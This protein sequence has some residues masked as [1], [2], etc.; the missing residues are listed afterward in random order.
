MSSCP[1][2][3]RSLRICHF[4][5]R[6]HL[7]Q[8]ARDGILSRQSASQRQ[9]D[10]PAVT[11]PLLSSRIVSLSPDLTICICTRNR[12]EA[13]A[14]ALSSIKDSAAPVARVV[15]SDDGPDE[16]T[17]ALVV[18]S[19]LPAT[20]TVGPGRGLAANRNHALRHVQSRYVLFLD[21][22]CRLAPNF[23]DL[24]SAAMQEHESR[25]GHGSV[26]VTGAEC[27]NGTIVTPSDQ[28]FL[29][30]QARPYRECVGLKTVV[31]NS[32]VFPTDR[33]QRALFDSRL[34]YGCEEVDLTTRLVADGATIVYCGDAVNDHLQSLDG[35]TGYAVE[36][37]AS[38]LYV[39]F[40]RYAFT[41]RRRGAACAFAVLAPL[42]MLV[43]AATRR[44]GKLTVTDALVAILRASAHALS[45]AFEH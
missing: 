21:D 4:L 6:H 41:D 17:R 30:F 39:T 20:Y 33:V 10:L 26:I 5:R 37:A 28:T 22:D 45:F 11:P 16:A 35:R 18:N 38:R 13:L 43:S 36:A 44:A 14:G 27:K 8:D 34:R 25:L 9:M 7:R 31:I 3:R 24:T 40:K 1:D 12:V 32:A 23:W 19:P 29:G 15:V 2:P 42:H